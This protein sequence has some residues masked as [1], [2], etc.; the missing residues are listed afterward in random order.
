[1]VFDPNAPAS[2]WAPP[3]AWGAYID[4]FGAPDP[5]ALAVPGAPVVEEVPVQAVAVPLSPQEE[6]QIEIDQPR[7]TPQ[8]EA[9]IEMLSPELPPPVPMLSQAS[10]NELEPPPLA[11]DAV[12]DPTYK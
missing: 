12:S 5:Y 8:E 11:V 10:G 6:A 4:Q 2:P 1:M 3:P 7:L 9:G